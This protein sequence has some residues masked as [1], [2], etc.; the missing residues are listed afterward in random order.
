M[1]GEPSEERNEDPKKGISLRAYVAIQRR[2]INRGAVPRRRR[3]GFELGVIN[4]G[5]MT[6]KYMGG[7]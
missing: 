7:N 3:K 2:V 4:C 1:V 5:K 6:R